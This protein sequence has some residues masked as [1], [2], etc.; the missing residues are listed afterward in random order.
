MKVLKPKE[1]TRVD[2]MNVNKQTKADGHNIIF[3]LWSGGLDSTYLIQKLLDEDNNNVVWAS[4]VEICN[5]PNKTKMELE[6]VGKLTHIFETLYPNRFNYRGTSISVDVKSPAMRFGMEQ[7]PV[8]LMSL[9]SITPID[10]KQIAI[11]YIMN[12]CAISYLSEIKGVIK[13]YNKICQTPLPPVIFPLSKQNKNDI[14]W[15]LKKELRDH[16]VTCENP[17]L[18]DNKWVQCGDCVP[19]TRNPLVVS[20][21]KEAKFLATDKVICIKKYCEEIKSE[22]RPA[23]DYSD[24]LL[25]MLMPER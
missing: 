23:C 14:C 9:A 19:C 7:M 13:A 15:A 24:N 6:A 17:S 20:A 1:L 25:R 21:K 2:T 5:N 22:I 4:Y 12:D 10:S 8:W 11:G 16:V 3:A 18:I